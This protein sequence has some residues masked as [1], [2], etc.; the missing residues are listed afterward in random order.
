MLMQLLTVLTALAIPAV[1]IAIVDDWFLRPRGRWRVPV[2]GVLR[3]AAAAAGGAAAAAAVRAARL[4]HGAGHGGG[5]RRPGVAGRAPAG[6]AAAEARGARP[7]G[8]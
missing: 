5:G 6:R 8:R 7:R 3:T 2:G 4:Q 1:L